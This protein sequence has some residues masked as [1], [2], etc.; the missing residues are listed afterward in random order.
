MF[1]VTSPDNGIA[2]FNLDGTIRYVP[3]TDYCQD[4]IPDSFDYAICFDNVCD[5]TTVLVFVDCTSD[6]NFI[7][8]NALSP[9]GDGVNDVFQIDGI[10]D[11]PN[12][13]VQ[14]FNRWGNMVF[15]MAGYKNEWNGDWGRDR[16]MLPDGTYFY[17]FDT[18]EGERFSGFLEIRR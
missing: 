15:E 1:I 18:G 6:R 17:L 9:N 7:I 16:E 14:I 4:S 2:T 3:V 13:T 12:N 5:T 11:F 10:E 8:F